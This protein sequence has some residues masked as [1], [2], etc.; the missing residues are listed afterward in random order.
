[1]SF[2]KRRE[3]ETGNTY[4]GYNSLVGGAG[5][6]VH[7]QIWNPSN[8]GVDIYLKSCRVCNTSGS[9]IF[10]EYIK[11]TA[12]AATLRRYGRNTKDNTD[13][14]ATMRTSEESSTNTHG[15]SQGINV[16]VPDDVPVEMFS[17][18][19]IKLE[20]GEGYL[21]RSLAGQTSYVNYEWEEIPV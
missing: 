15:G 2:E 10:V 20:P 1:M 7:Y 8:S 12:A 18:S 14:K 16:A 11:N 13:S 6:Y 17:D 5:N 19:Y 9:S 4:R 21:V 3:V